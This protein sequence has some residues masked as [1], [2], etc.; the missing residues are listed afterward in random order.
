MS[1]ETNSRQLTIL[2]IKVHIS[3]IERKRG[4]F[5]SS[6]IELPSTDRIR[7]RPP[8]LRYANNINLKQERF[9]SLLVSTLT[10]TCL[11]KKPNPAG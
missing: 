5:F 8:T 9:F 6:I 11:S 4:I 10:L 7:S 1:S 3:S 2:G